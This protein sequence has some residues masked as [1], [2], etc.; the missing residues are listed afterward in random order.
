MA[1][2]VLSRK[3]AKVRKAAARPRKREFTHPR[4]QK[5]LLNAFTFEMARVI[6]RKNKEP[7]KTVLD[8]MLAVAD[9]IK[10]AQSSS[11]AK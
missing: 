2:A 10:G 3:G 5:V 6:A 11:L 9:A 4:T 1:T 7:M 8:R